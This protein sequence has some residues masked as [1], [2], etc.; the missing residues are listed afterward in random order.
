[1]IDDKRNVLGKRN[2]TEV[3]ACQICDNSELDSVLFL[4]FLPPVNLMQKAGQALSEQPAYPAELLHCK[5]CGLAQLGLV[6]SASVLFPAEY[7]YTSS[8]TRILRENFA[9]LSEEARALYGLAPN[10]LVVD[11]GSNDG[12]LLS[13]FK[14]HARVL[15]IT[16]EDIGKLAVARGIPTLFTYF[17]KAAVEEVL[18]TQGKA[19]L[20]T[21]TNVFAHIDQ[22]HEVVRSI[23]A[24]LADD[25]IFVSE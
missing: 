12:N 21:A 10:D 25:G 24:L 9:E 15:G 18:K 13:N 16:P 5:R 6:V 11:I 23:D 4:G 22:V 2:S 19:K 17:G 7:P 14:D 20:V 3:T 1:M 8:T